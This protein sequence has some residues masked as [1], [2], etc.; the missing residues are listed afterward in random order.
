[1]EDKNLKNIGL[2]RGLANLS[3]IR[4]RGFW[5]ATALLLGLAI[6][7]TASAITTL[8]QG[9]LTNETLSLGSIVS[10]QNNTSD[11]VTAAT[12]VNANNILGVVINADSSLLSLS[13]NQD[14][15]V[16]VATSGV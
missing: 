12:T 2:L 16:Q 9:Y 7:A 8:S 10:L 13:T 6:P 4:T 3:N 15:Q 11:R 5:P 14:N 1:M